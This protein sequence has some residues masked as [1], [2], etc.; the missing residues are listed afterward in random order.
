VE[1]QGMAGP[2]SI[3]LGWR[4]DGW[5]GQVRAMARAARLGVSAAASPRTYVIDYSAPNVAKPMH[6]GH[7]RSTIIGDALTRLLRFLGHT[8][9]TD[10][11]LG[12]WGTQFGILLYG[13]KHHL[14]AAAYKADPVAELARLYL[15]VRGLMKGDE[16]AEDNASPIAEA[17][18]QETAKLHAG[19]P[20]N[21]RLWKEF[22]PSCHEELNR[23]YRRLGILPFDQTLGESFYNPMLPGV[24]A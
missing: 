4:A 10:N 20:E 19:D 9:I 8:V 16:D 7:L 23:V 14:D 6:V 1:N 3:I 17:C 21:N 24:V 5:A 15:L 11:H 12:D 13:Y 2:A 18:R 22:M